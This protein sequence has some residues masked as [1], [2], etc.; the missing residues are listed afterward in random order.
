MKEVLRS[1][2][3]MAIQLLRQIL[4]DE[5]IETLV[6]DE[7]TGALFGGI[8]GIGPRLMVADDD[9]FDRALALA[10]EAGLAG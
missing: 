5:G 4:A 10:K 6:L 3:V 8:G 2:N 1:G 9:D 7:H